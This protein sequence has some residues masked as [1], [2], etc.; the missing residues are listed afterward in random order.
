M[1]RDRQQTHVFTSESM[2]M[3]LL[4][5]IVSLHGAPAMGQPRRSTVV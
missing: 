1:N 2:L 5:L 3:C 4:T